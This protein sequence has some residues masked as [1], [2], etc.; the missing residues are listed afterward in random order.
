MSSSTTENSFSPPEPLRL[1]LY[2]FGSM[3][4]PTWAVMQFGTFV[5]L[6]ILLVG[7]YEILQPVTGLGQRIHNLLGKVPYAL[8]ILS[9][10]PSALILA[11]VLELCEAV[12]ILFLPETRFPNC[13]NG[14]RPSTVG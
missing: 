7:S 5:M 12:V 14:T 6:G 1:K 9:W 10:C 13:P 3:S 2:G 8:I 11:G 4:F